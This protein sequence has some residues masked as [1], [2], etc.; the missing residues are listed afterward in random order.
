MSDEEE[1]LTL[2]GMPV[3]LDEYAPRGHVY[4]IEGKLRVHPDDYEGM[5]S[6]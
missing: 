2:W 5:R 1:P 3:I 4:L 6:E